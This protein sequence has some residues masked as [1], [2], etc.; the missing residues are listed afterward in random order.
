[1][2]GGNAVSPEGPSPRSAEFGN[3]AGPFLRFQGGTG[4]GDT[5]WRGS[6]LFLTRAAASAS[7]EAAP[8]PTLT[9]S[10]TNAGSDGAVL[11][12][13]P[14]KL[15][16]CL[17][18]VFWRFDIE[19][20]LVPWQRPVAYSISAGEPCPGGGQPLPCVGI[21]AQQAALVVCVRL[22]IDHTRHACCA[23]CVGQDETRT[24]TFWLPAVGQPMHW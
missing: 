3:I 18:W 21:L 8:Q 16:D 6:V 2:G 4:P 24:F 23:S 7:A 20:Q 9:L 15:S 12:L 19:L 17:G 10:D 1:M 5:S 22:P 11:H 14:T 13:T